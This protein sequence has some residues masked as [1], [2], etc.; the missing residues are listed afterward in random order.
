MRH[1]LDPE[2]SQN[3]Q[4]RRLL[5]VAVGLD[6]VARQT[7]PFIAPFGMRLCAGEKLAADHL[8]I[9]FERAQ[10]ITVSILRQELLPEIG[11]SRFEL[12][13]SGKGLVGRTHEGIAQVVAGAVEISKANQV[14]AT[15]LP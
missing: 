13:I 8:R 14:T 3:V 1:E 12:N 10:A 9:G 15:E 7:F 5:V 6:R 11:K 4:D 2:C